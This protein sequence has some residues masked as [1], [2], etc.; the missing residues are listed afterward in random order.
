MSLSNRTLAES[1]ASPSQVIYPDAENTKRLANNLLDL[2]FISIVAL[3]LTY[4]ADLFPFS[5]SS[6]GPFSTFFL[7]YG[8]LVLISSVYYIVLEGLFGWTLGKLIT[9]TRVVRTD[10]NVKPELR[11]IVL[12]TLCRWIPTEPYSFLKGKPGGWHDHWSRTRTVDVRN[13]CCRS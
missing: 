10:R 11:A 5:P 6:H 7:S 4:L 9:G 12:R 3:V 8:G 1:H 13:D 2:L